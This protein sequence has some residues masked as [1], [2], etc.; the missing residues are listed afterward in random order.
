MNVVLCDDHRVF[1]DSL[2]VVLEANG[3]T[4][5]RATSPDEALDTVAS[6]EIDACVMDVTFP[7]ASGLTAVS[8]VRRASPATRVLVLTG[9]L[10]DAIEKTAMAAGAVG[11]LPKDDEIACLLDALDACAAGDE[12][13]TVGGH[14][15]PVEDPWRRDPLAR[16]L[17]VR[18]R[19]VL[20]GIAR[21]ETTPALARRLGIGTATV[22]THVQNVLAK[23]GVHSRLEAV[24]FALNHSL[25]ATRTFDRA[26]SAP[27]PTTG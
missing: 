9:F 10:D 26:G 11:C 18:E 24:A 1:L 13:V 14:A 5:F 16:F 27:S 20:E 21:G 8:E 19:E 12:T 6:H 7:Q 22:R 15:R 4:V 25:V 2:A 23:L 17:T 3:H